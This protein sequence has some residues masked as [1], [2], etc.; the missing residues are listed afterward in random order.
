MSETLLNEI[1]ATK[2]EAPSALRERVRAL[3]ARSPHA[4]PF[5]PASGSMGLAAARAR[6]AGDGPRGAHRGGRDRAHAR[7]HPRRGDR[8]SAPRLTRPLHR[9]AS[10]PST[11]APKARFA[12]A[13]REAAATG[14][15]PTGARPA[16]ALRGG[17]PPPRRRRR[18]ALGRDEAGP[19]D[20]ARATAAA[21]P[22]SST[23]RRRR[24][25]APPRSR[26]ASRPPRCRAQWPSS[27]SSA[28][29]S[30]SATGS[31]TCRCR[32]TRSSPR[33]RQRS[34]RSRSSSP[35]LESTTLSDADRVVLQSRLNDARRS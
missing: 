7:R 8:R 20:R 27:P 4:T 32:P 16:P 26:S 10:S 31:T 15:R 6:R 35:R 5:S 29:S 24:A 34:G 2:P 22:R 30:A 33:S 3:A 25:S 12:V 9:D 21:S 14:R 17:A 23:T 19:A 11:A 13:C 1:R 28:R 18:G